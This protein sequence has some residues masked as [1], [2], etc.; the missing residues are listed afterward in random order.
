VDRERGMRDRGMRERAT[1]RG[2]GRVENGLALR[3]QSSPSSYAVVIQLLAG[4]SYTMRTSHRVNIVGPA[5][6][7]G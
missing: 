3:K 4:G 5:Y 7:Q 6:G 1:E 2:G